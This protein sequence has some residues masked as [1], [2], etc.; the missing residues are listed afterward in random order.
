M[1]HHLMK[2]KDASLARLRTMV[3]EFFSCFRDPYT[4]NPLSNLYAVFGFAWGMPVPFVTV[5]LVILTLG[6]PA[7]ARSVAFVVRTYHFLAIFLVHP[8][9]FYLVFGALGTMHKRR[10]ELVLSEAAELAATKEQLIVK[11]RMAMIGQLAAGVAHEI[12]NPV[13]VVL[14]KIGYQKSL[15]PS[16]ESFT[17]QAVKDIDK[18][19]NHLLRVAEIT[20]GLLSF[21]RQSVGLQSQINFP[22]LLAETLTFMDHGFRKNNISVIRKFE[23]QR[24]RFSGCAG[25]L[26][27]VL[28]NLF[29][30]ASDAMILPGRRTLT[31]TF[32]ETSGA[33]E[34]VV[35]DTGTGIPKELQ[36]KILEP[37][38]STKGVGKGTGLGLSISYGI[39]TKHKGTLTFV[40]T[41]GKGAAFTICFPYDS[42]DN[43]SHSAL[44]ATSNPG[45]IDSTSAILRP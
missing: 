19:E 30:N 16:M 23:A 14:A 18:F 6:L 44:N 22:Q 38:F 33:F 7:D 5:G 29:S 15:L 11:E 10:E 21:A 31:V 37:F 2:K 43:D 42:G 39:V 17:V 12:N 40:S 1:P 27:Q 28:L 20:R 13:C 4:V 8:V 26:Q 9:L 41:P 45:A 32:T 25:E 3:P 34:I 36:D 35:A 24:Q